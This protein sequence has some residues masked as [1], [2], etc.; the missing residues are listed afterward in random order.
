MSLISPR[1]LKGFRDTLPESE[2]VRRTL[3]SHLESAFR[4]FGYVPID[5]PTLEYTEVLL[6]KGGGETDKQVF[7]FTDHGGRD[8]SMRFDLTV[9]FAR[10]MAAHL[11]EL[12]TPFRRYHI[13][14]AWRGENTQRG[15]YR[16]FVQ[17]DFDIV[18]VDSASADADTLLTAIEAFRVLGVERVRLHVAHRGLFNRF[19]STLGVVEKSGDILRTVDKLRKTGRDKT[20]ADLTSLVGS[21]TARRILEYVTADGP[22]DDVIDSIETL[23]GGPAEDTQR[24]RAVFSALEE[25]GAG[26][27]VV[28]DPSITRGL[29]YYTGLVFETF[30]EDLPEIGSVCSGGRYNDL[31]SLYTRQELPGVG[32]S[33]GLDRLLAALEQLEQGPKAVRATDILVFCFD[34]ALLGYYHRLARDLR[35][36]GFSTEVY[37][38]AKKLGQQFTYAE[39]KGIPIAVICGPDEKEAGRINCKDLRTRESF[40]ASGVPTAVEEISRRLGAHATRSTL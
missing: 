9:P 8:V 29:D 19:L 5:T 13:G 31:A 33:V 12:Y 22:A 34:E 38:E 16:E 30:L 3:T 40:Q 17:C 2:L 36:A 15:R 6:G 10:Y 11:G 7:R 24:I 37:P 4:R 28:Y 39:K 1:V 35:A 21:E 23:A 18:G 26:E 14:K 20:E 27:M 25:T 32:G